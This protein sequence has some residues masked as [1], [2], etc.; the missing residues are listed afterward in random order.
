MK[1]FDEHI[2]RYFEGL[3]SPEEEKELKDFLVSPEGQDP[4]Y[5]EVRAVMGFFATGKALYA[6]EGY[7]KKIVPA[8]FRFA[9]FAAAAAAAA[10]AAVAALLIGIGIDAHRNAEIHEMKNTL[11]ELLDD[12]SRPDITEGLGQMF[13]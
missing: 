13:K 8:R 5:D 4:V 3:A 11:A 10:A 2:T 9:R 12:N 6:T 1:T 7:S